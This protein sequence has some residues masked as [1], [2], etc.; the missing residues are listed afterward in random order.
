M[1]Q[2]L[3]QEILRIHDFVTRFQRKQNSKPFHFIFH[4]YFH[5]LS[6]G[7]HKASTSI[8]HHRAFTSA[9]VFSTLLA[10]STTVLIQAIFGRPCFRVPYGLQS[11]FSSPVSRNISS[12]SPYGVP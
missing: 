6:E 4:K 5:L 2:T 12:R 9:Q 7:G 1:Q 8:R 11:S 3:K 10:S